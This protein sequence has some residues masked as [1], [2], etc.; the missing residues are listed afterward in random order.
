MPAASTA[1][2]V[3]TEAGHNRRRSLPADRYS[4]S[5]PVL[6][7]CTCQQMCQG[8]SISCWV[9]QGAA[10]KR[11][12]ACLCTLTEFQGTTQVV[13][14]MHVLAYTEFQGTTQ[15]VCCMHV[16]A[17]RVPGHDASQV[18]ADGVEAVLLDVAVLV[19]DEVGCVTLQGRDSG[20][21]RVL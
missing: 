13:C 15:E 9:L 6:G 12:D 18:G 11:Y 14:Y 8:N 3:V 4:T 10:S 5:P 16:H 20:I 19:H 2:T 1:Q 7:G 21:H 17:Y